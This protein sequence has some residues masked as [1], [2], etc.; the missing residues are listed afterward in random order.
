[1]GVGLTAAAAAL[2]TLALRTAGS[3]ALGLRRIEALLAAL[4]NPHRRLHCL[5]VA[6]TN[7]KGSVV[8]TLDAVL[9][10]RGFRVGRY[11]SPHLVDFRERIVIDGAM[12]ESAVVER[13]VSAHL[14]MIESSGASFFEATTALAFTALAD[15]ALDIAVIEVGLGGRLDATN[16]ITPLVAGVTSIGLDHTEWLGPTTREIAAEKA[17]I[18]K[19]GA[20]AVIGELD[21]EIRAQLV[22]HAERAGAAPI[23]VVADEWPSGVVQVSAAGTTVTLGLPDG[24]L[25]ATTPLV[26]AHQAQNLATALAMLDALP[27]PWR[28]GPREAAALLPSVSLPGRFQRIGKFIFDVAH[29]PDGAAVLARTLLAVRPE[30]PIWVLLTVLTDKDWRGMMRALAPY[31]AGF[32]LSRAPTAPSARAWDPAAAAAWAQGEGLPVVLEPD[33]DAAL[34]EAARRGA[35]VLVTGSFHTVGDT[36]GRLQ[37]SGASG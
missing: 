11:T 28:V 14:P 9:R 34:A 29:N 17:G 32:V 10:A 4:G 23:R 30:P 33:F 7:G 8:A 37:N 24:P 36:F 27:A 5:H 12:I 20:A 19:A 6:G 13:F 18:F 16:V 3:D 15:A 35:T 31:V 26:G 1:M 25:T 2:E 22:G 21:P